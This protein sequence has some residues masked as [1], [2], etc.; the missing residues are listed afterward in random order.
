M[1]NFVQTGT[2]ASP[3][4]SEPITLND[5]E[6]QC[7]IVD[8]SAEANT[9]ELMISAV[10]ER[11]EQ[12][13]RRALIRKTEVLTLDAFPSGRNFLNLPKPPLKTVVSIK[14]IDANCVEQ[15]LDANGYRVITTSEPGYVLP[16][17]GLNWPTTQNDSDVI[18]VVYTCGYLSD[19]V[20]KA[21]K[22]WSLLQVANLYEN[23]ESQ[24]V[25]MGRSTVFNLDA[26]L[27]DG[28]IE[29]YRLMRL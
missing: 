4:I 8:L 13:T 22:Q 14:Y 20:P 11:A 7:R 6:G 9:I 24:G 25:A 3:L 1:S 21:I 5:V 23:R 29:S 15:T 17:Y 26:T 16:L 10:R 18:T 12:I 28:L 2:V 19:E 27:C